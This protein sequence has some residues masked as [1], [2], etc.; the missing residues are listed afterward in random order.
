MGVSVKSH[1]CI[2]WRST[3]GHRGGRGLPGG[4]QQRRHPGVAGPG[5]A[6]G[7]CPT[8]LAPAIA[9]LHQEKGWARA[10]L[11]RWPVG[12]P[13]SAGAMAGQGRA[14]TGRGAAEDQPWWGIT[15]AGTDGPGG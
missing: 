14:G 12:G 5:L 2:V 10:G 15:G 7:A 1:R 6:A 9:H 11:G 13:G 8:A 3:S 4:W